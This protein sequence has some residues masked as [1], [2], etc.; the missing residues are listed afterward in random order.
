MTRML[1]ERE[2]TLRIVKKSGLVACF[3]TVAAAAP[4]ASARAP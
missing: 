2:G 4:D 3:Y 1:R